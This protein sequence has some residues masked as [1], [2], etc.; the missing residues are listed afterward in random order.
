MRSNQHFVYLQGP[1][2]NSN[3]E[4]IGL[5]R[6]A[7]PM[8]SFLSYPNVLPLLEN[9]GCMPH[10][11]CLLRSLPFTTY[12]HTYILPE[13][14]LSKYIASHL[15]LV[16]IKFHLRILSSIFQCNFKQPSLLSITPLIFVS[17]IKLLII[18]PTLSSKGIGL[19]TDPYGTDFQSEKH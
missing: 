3:T 12:I 9:Y 6:Q 1:R 8:S 15:S 11:H 2:L 10:G 17:L 5:W 16:G 7:N 18:P 4:C 13:F 14:D 19:S